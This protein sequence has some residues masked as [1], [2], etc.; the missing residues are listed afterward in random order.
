MSDIARDAPMNLQNAIRQ[1]A[2]LEKQNEEACEVIQES[3]N[4]IDTLN[5]QLGLQKSLVKLWKSDYAE[6]EQ[7]T[8]WQEIDSAPKETEVLTFCGGVIAVSIRYG[9]TWF[10]ADDED[11]NAYGVEPTHWKS[12]GPPPKQE[13]NTDDSTPEGKS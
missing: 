8:Q 3:I 4:K 11:E 7:L 2:E 5:N 13:Q 10:N 1:I 6:L 12:L 9:I